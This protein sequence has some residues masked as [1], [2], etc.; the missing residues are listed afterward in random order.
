[1]WREGFV[2]RLQWI[3]VDAPPINMSAN[4]SV[5]RTHRTEIE[6]PKFVQ[7]ANRSRQGE[8]VSLS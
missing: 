2:Q 8:T 7:I 6:L 5:V 1:M 4:N 3:V